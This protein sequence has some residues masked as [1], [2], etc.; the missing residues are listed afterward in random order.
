MPK[1]AIVPSIVARTEAASATMTVFKSERR[2]ASLW[3]SLMY[4]S[5]VKPV[6]LARDFETLNENTI[7]TSI[8]R[9]KKMYSAYI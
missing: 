9:Y 8:G 3:K 2:I 4:Q 5:K 7:S 1:A 6:Q